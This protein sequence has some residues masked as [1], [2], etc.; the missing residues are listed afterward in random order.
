MANVRLRNTNPLGAVDLPLLGLTLGAGEEFDCPAELAG[1]APTGTGD[2]FDPG[3]GLLAQVGNYQL[4]P[5]T[6]PKEV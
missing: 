2:Q 6:A 3:E 1:R 5:P 4:V